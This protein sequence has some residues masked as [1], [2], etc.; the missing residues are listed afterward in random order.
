VAMETVCGELSQDERQQY[1]GYGK[2]TIGGP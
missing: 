1:R 2:E